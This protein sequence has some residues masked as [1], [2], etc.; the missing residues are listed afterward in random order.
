MRRLGFRRGQK[1]AKMIVAA[2]FLAIA[3]GVAQADI[4]YG[5]VD[6]PTLENGCALSGTITT[7][8]N[9]GSLGNA[10]IVAFDVRISSSG[11]S[12]VG[13]VSGSGLVD[14]YSSVAATDLIASATS[15]NLDT[16]PP[17]QSVL[18]FEAGE[19]VLPPGILSN[20]IW[21]ISQTSGESEF[22][23]SSTLGVI[24]VSTQT[25]FLNE[26]TSGG[27]LGPLTAYHWQ[28]A[29][30]LHPGDANG[31]GR[32]DI[33]DLT[34]VLSNYGMSN[35]IFWNQG[36]FNYDGKVDIDDLTT[37]LSNFGTTYGSNLAA[38]PEPTAPVLVGVAVACLLA[39]RRRSSR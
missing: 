13:F 2:V 11:G 3:T 24:G 8:G 26:V 16:S 4:T 6:Y 37:V 28:I 35:G 30:A 21:S 7:N 36:D 32:V 38:V 39:W 25:F 9:I 5:I 14:Y 19:E 10:D 29:K 31:D 17:T 34:I 18:E 12:G 22:E 20:L 27:S 33:N 15:L 23:A 1:A